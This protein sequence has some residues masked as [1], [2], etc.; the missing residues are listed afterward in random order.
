MGTR[1]QRGDNVVYL[2][3]KEEPVHGTVTEVR[4]PESNSPT[5]VLDS[6]G[7]KY[8]AK[9]SKLR[10]EKGIEEEVE[11]TVQSMANE[12]AA[13]TQSTIMDEDADMIIAEYGDHIGVNGSTNNGTPDTSGYVQVEQGNSRYNERALRTFVVEEVSDKTGADIERIQ[14]V[15]DRKYGEKNELYTEVSGT[16]TLY[17]NID[18][19]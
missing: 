9:A 3:P 8:E 2:H 18:K 6:E 4:D 11:K 14:N 15:I 10:K 17:R 19:N 16:V 13:S 12:Q 7:R 1:Y 5:Y